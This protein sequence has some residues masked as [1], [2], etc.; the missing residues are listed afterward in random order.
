MFRLYENEITTYPIIPL[1][2]FSNRTTLISFTAYVGICGALGPDCNFEFCLLTKQP[3]LFYRG[4]TLSCNISGRI[5]WHSRPSE[6]TFHCLCY[7]IDLY[8][9]IHTFRPEATRE[10]GDDAPVR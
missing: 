3:L 2:I 4:E 7:G 9:A 8:E 6:S 5:T 1:A 10:V